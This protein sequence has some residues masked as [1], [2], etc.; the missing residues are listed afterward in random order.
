[1]ISIRRICWTAVVPI[2]VLFILAG[3]GRKDVD[4]SGNIKMRGEKPV[5]MRGKQKGDLLQKGIAS[6]YGKPYHGRKTSNGERYDMWALTA[7]HKSLP[8]GTMVEVVN[9]E[10]K[11]S[12][13][14]RIND[15][16]PFIRGRI[17]D[18]SRKAAAAINME[19]AGT[20]RVALYL[21]GGR[22]RV[23]DR[24]S[25]PLV[26]ESPPAGAAF[27][28]IQVGSFRRAGSSGSGRLADRGLRSA[29]QDRE[30]RIH[31]SRTGGALRFPGRGG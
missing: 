2:V 19:G 25:K 15:R 8:F 1:M 14:V 24:G 16:G 12:V 21:A 26:R 31:V 20:A 6:W 4:R 27:W 5:S 28:T 13:V 29:G 3:C 17:I 30:S 10:N 11:R 18:L 23:P 7:A 22:A 9:L